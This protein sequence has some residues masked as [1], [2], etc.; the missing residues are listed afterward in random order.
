[1]NLLNK[2][3]QQAKKPDGVV[4]RIMVS[5][6]NSAHYKKTKWGLEKLNIGR[7]ACVLDIGCGGGNII[8]LLSNL[9]QMDVKE[10]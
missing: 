2:L 4:G 6:M 3:I 9:N 7:N 1:M 10:K 5:I 8:S